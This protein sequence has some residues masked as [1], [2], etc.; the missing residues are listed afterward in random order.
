MLPLFTNDRSWLKALATPSSDEISQITHLAV[1]RGPD[2]PCTCRTLVWWMDCHTFV[3]PN[4]MPI[5]KD[6]TTR[7]ERCALRGVTQQA[8]CRKV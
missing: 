5:G 3:N 4:L 8:A 1:R 6:H 7:D 2:K